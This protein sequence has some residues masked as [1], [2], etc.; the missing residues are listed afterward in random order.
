MKNYMVFGRSGKSAFVKN[1]IQDFLKKKPDALLYGLFCYSFNQKEYAPS[2]INIPGRFIFKDINMIYDELISRKENQD[3]NFS[4]IIIIL[5]NLLFNNLLLKTNGENSIIL[6]TVEKLIDIVIGG[7]G[8][9]IVI[10]ESNYSPND[11]NRIIPAD[12][13]EKTDLLL[14]N[15]TKIEICE[16]YP[17]DIDHNRIKFIENSNLAISEIRYKENETVFVKTDRKFST[18]NPLSFKLLTK[19]IQI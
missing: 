6:K 19:R 4:P 12:L 18:L 10:K 5:E 3:L 17:D 11:V 13:R 7:S 8:I 9:Y 1:K 15:L 16:T 14:K 2:Q